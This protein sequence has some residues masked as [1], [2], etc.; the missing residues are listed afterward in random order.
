MI[1]LKNQPFVSLILCI[2]FLFL[3]DWFQAWGWFFLS[4]IPFEC[5]FFFCFRDFR[6]AVK[7]LVWNIPFTD[8]LIGFRGRVSMSSR[9][10][11]NSLWTRL[12]LNSE[13]CLPLLP[14]AEIKGVCYH[15]LDI[16]TYLLVNVD[17][18]CLNLDFIVE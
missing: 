4:S 14:T 3:F 12:V 5:D 13:I 8:W 15:H 9:L 17:R 2:L 16:P 11:S 1:F 6:C 18:Y 10:P 7:L